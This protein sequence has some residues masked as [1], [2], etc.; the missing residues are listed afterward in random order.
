MLEKEEKGGDG[1]GLCNFIC[2]QLLRDM[3]PSHSCIPTTPMPCRTGCRPVRN[4]QRVGVQDG[5][6]YMR[7][8]LIPS[9]AILFR[10]GVS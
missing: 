5:S 8:K 3:L 7:V 9:A 1:R 6:V 10:L 2:V 4:A